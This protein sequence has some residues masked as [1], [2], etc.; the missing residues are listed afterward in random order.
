MDKTIRDL[1]NDAILHEA[2]ARYAIAADAI[3]PGG[4]FESFI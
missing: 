4:G 3:E 2:M 1:Y